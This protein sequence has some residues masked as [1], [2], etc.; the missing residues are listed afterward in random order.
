MR[1][2][3]MLDLMFSQP[4]F[5]NTVEVGLQFWIASESNRVLK[6]KLKF[7]LE[8]KCQVGF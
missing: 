4:Q 7:V 1:L 2:E 6:V 3:H 8:L 5:R